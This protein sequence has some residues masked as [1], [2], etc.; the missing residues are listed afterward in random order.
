MTAA[1]VG[2]IAI[3]PAPGGNAPRCCH[4]VPGWHSRPDRRSDS[5]AIRINTLAPSRGAVS[6]SGGSVQAG[7]SV[8]GGGRGVHAERSAS[9]DQSLT[10]R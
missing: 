8:G 3:C 9:G 10:S 2:R 5:D 7:E 4:S 6:Q 1:R